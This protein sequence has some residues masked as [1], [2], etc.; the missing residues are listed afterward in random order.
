MHRVGPYELKERVGTG[1]SAEVW[2]ARHVGWR[3]PVALKVLKERPGG[4]NGE[5]LR[6]EIRLVAGL[7]H[8]AIIRVLDSGEMPTNGPFPSGSPFLVMELMEG[9]S[10]GD[11]VGRIGWPRLRWV[12]LRVLDGLAHAHAHG[13]IHRDLKPANLLRSANGGRVVISDFGISGRLDDRREDETVSGTPS[14]MAPEQLLGVWREQGPWTDLYSLGSVAW[15]L[16]TG[17]WVFGRGSEAI[18]GHMR[19][20]PGD[21]VPRASCPPG[22]ETWLRR[23]LRKP[24]GDRFQRAAE[25]AAVLAAL[26][27]TVDSPPGFESLPTP[28][29]APTL[30]LEPVIG[31]L[32]RSRHHPDRVIP[33]LPG[34][35]REPSGQQSSTRTRGLGIVGMRTLRIVGRS[36]ERDRLW[37]ALGEVIDAGQTAGLVLRGPAGVG[38]SRLA[39]WLC[40]RAHELGVG[41][42]LIGRHS[43]DEPEG[44]GPMIARSVH[45]HGLDGDALGERLAKELP[46]LSVDDRLGLQGLVRPGTGL[47]VGRSGWREAILLRWMGALAARRPLIVWLD[48][49]HWSASSLSLVHA[50]IRGGGCGPVLF[51][52]TVQDEGAARCPSTAEALAALPLPSLP[53]GP[54]PRERCWELVSELLGLTAALTAQVVDRAA[55]SPLLAIQLVADQ[56]ARDQLVVGESGLELRPGAELRLPRDLDELWQERLAAVAR[57]RDTRALE[58]AALLGS[59]VSWAELEAALRELDLVLMMDLLKD[60]FDEHLLVP[61]GQLGFRFAHG[62]LREV[63]LRRVDEASEGPRLHAVCAVAIET[64]AGSR[65]DVL[66]RRGRHLFHAGALH[67]ALPLLRSA[68]TSLR[69]SGRFG[70]GAALLELCE[71]ALL[72][73]GIDADDP[74]WA[75]HRCQELELLVEGGAVDAGTAASQ[76]LLSDARA[77]GWARAEATSLLYQ[78]RSL[79]SQG[80]LLGALARLAEAIALWRR[81]GDARQL[82]V[83]LTDRADVLTDLGRHREAES[84]YHAAARELE[85]LPAGRDLGCVFV[86]LAELAR[87]RKDWTVA[88]SWL[89]RGRRAY[90]ADGNRWGEAVVC[91]DLADYDRREGR[92]DAALEGF[93][94]AR[95]RQVALGYRPFVPEVNI[96]LTLAAM[97]RDEEAVAVLEP[98]ETY[99][100]EWRRARFAAHVRAGLLTSLARLDRRPDFAMRLDALDAFLGES[101]LVDEEFADFLQDGSAAAAARSWTAEAERARRLAEAQRLAL[102]PGAP[103]DRPGTS[104]G[105]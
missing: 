54:L 31:H 3:L 105:R 75:E 67:A 56:V 46:E 33:R 95:R 63:L 11:E 53:V 78:G 104:P 100:E 41:S 81:L 98:L 68:I 44:I 97:G 92:L 99:L 83:A 32:D 47:R 28:A 102:G 84:H 25:A 59:E 6:H 66:A 10:L 40:T 55:G 86:G 74:L 64:T 73:I 43:E 20:Q 90:A 45:G 29:E 27:Q 4:A 85:P 61:D 49:V 96:G 18:A 26:P 2:R 37:S 15:T 87:Q 7:E 8:P 22:F 12:L 82:G 52:L 62:M 19:E 5:A 42:V 1:G 14:Y 79:R 23:L 91:N 93:R 80:R 39:W 101:G 70:D 35:W 65:E 69:R 60:L 76:R 89:E 103:V 71:E 50:A 58:L 21:F 48:D 72:R 24:P 9:G 51:V 94:E 88:R 16:A 38:K 30:V 36:A 34:T 57:G 13:V 77:H 17:R